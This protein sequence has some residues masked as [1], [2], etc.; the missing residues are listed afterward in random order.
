[1]R[2]DHLLRAVP[3]L[4]TRG[5][6]ATDILEVDYD[7][8]AAGPGGLFCCLR[9]TKNDG[10][11]FAADAVSRGAVALL[12]ERPLG[13]N[14]PQAI[15]ADA[16]AAMAPVSAELYGHPSENLTVV[17]V[18]GTNGKTTTTQIL[19]AIFDAAGRPAGVLG[20]MSGSRTTPEAPVLQRTLARFVAEGKVA[21]AIEVSSVGLVQHRVDAVRFA[22]GIFTNLSPEHLD[23]HR[24][25]DE[26]FAA[27]SRLF[28]PERV[29]FGV[30]NADDEYGRR[31]LAS[32]PVP[33]RPFS[34]DDAND[35][36]LGVGSS[37]FTWRGCRVD[38]PLDGA[39]NVS[40]AL[41]AA[42]AAYELGV[43]AE[44]IARGLS[45]MPAVAGHSEAVE[46]GQ[47]FRVVIDYAHTPTALEA[48]LEAARAA[49]GQSGRVIVVFGCGGQ[50]DPS[51]RAPMGRAAST[52]ADLVIV[53]SDNPRH[54]NPRE[55][56]EQ[57]LVGATGGAEVL[58]EE[59]RRAAIS[60]ALARA[61][62][63]DVV[64]IAGKG[65]ET[66]QTVRD[67]VLPFDDKAVVLDLL[68]ATG[69]GGPA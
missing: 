66:G 54:E 18:T 17:G 51:K 13:V 65:H 24:T 56:I 45:A 34:M 60:V 37:S 3:V 38:L 8:S 39:F 47:T 68:R 41:A 63:G 69:G 16:R 20:T 49:A 19:R 7:S 64:V 30:V 22:A 50:R 42:T 46:A 25:M 32:A 57:I 14:V 36:V 31:L 53:T 12:G 9:G 55:I 40:N 11:A 62:S 28:E 23:D 5:D 6:L 52:N 10:H 26:Y 43:D 59:D 33:M 67:A 29:A 15:V 48:V 58:V 4:D 21:A 1:L 61:N 27:K 35:L 44:A 2:L